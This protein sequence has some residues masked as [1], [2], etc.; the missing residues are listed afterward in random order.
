MP[1]RK[2]RLGD[3]VE[4]TKPAFQVAAIR[5]S[6]KHVLHESGMEGHNK[7]LQICSKRVGG[8]SVKYNPLQMTDIRVTGLYRIVLVPNQKAHPLE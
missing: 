5:V 7:A 2:E 4:R 1:A 8:I 6:R 3:I